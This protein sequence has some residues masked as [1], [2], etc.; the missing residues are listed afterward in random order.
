MINEYKTIAFIE[1]GSH[2]MG[3]YGIRIE[4][5]GTALPD[6]KLDRIQHVAYSAI[7]S[8]E[9]EI[10]AEAKK[11][12]PAEQERARA[13]SLGIL[14]CFSFPIYAEKTPNGYCSL[15][16]CRHLP[17]FVVTTHIGR[18]KIGWRKRVIEIDWQET[19]QTK[20][21]NELFPDEQVTKRDRSIHA[22][23]LADAKRYIEVVTIAGIINVN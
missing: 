14:E 9:Q 4:V 19:R 22:W 1:A 16:C 18:F 23:S 11:T 8:V 5:A 3:R 15:A 13:E 6:M 10:I 7:Q 12:D 21:A 17:W 2:G 20:T